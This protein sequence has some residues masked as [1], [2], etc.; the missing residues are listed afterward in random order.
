MSRPLRVLLVKTS[1]L[2][3]VIHTLPALTDAMHAVPGIRFDWVVEENFQEIPAWHPAV[4]RVLPVAVRRWRKNLRETWKSGEWAAFKARIR[5][6]DYDLA[7]DAQGLLKSAFLVRHARCRKVGFDRASAR[8]A[9]AARVYDHGYDVPKGIHAV[10]RLRQLFAQAFAYPVPG[11][12][13]DYGVDFSRLPASEVSGDYV[14]FLHATTWDTKHWPEAYWIRL[15]RLAGEAGLGVQLPWGNEAE[16]ERAGRIAAASHGHAH[17]LPR[18]SLSG[19]AGVLA[20]ARVVIAVDTGLCHLAA[21]MNTPTVSLYGPTN[22][23]LTGAE[24][25]NQVHLASEL[26]C[27]PCMSRKC[28]YRGAPLDDELDGERFHVVPPCFAT[29][30]PDHVWASAQP[31]LR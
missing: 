22:P 20:G 8:E 9:I 12:P 19:I 23:G 2:G 11:S 15:S 14:V 5:D 3:D 1:S 24:G 21:A 7:I 31:L 26:A 6:G 25:R 10:T 13:V 16:R 4:G 18:L 27:A 29:L 28:K 30:N 17:V